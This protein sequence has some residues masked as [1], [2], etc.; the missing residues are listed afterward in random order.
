[1]CRSGAAGHA[2]AGAELALPARRP[3]YVGSIASVIGAG[4]PA[5][6]F[7]QPPKN[8]ASIYTRLSDKPD[9]T[10]TS[11]ESQEQE[12]RRLAADRG[13]TVIAVHKDPGYSGALR[14]RPGFT[15]WLDDAK[16]ARCDH[17]LAH[18]LDRVSR[19]SLAGLA[20]FMDVVEGLGP[21]GKPAHTPPRFLSV[22]DR[23]DSTSASW[24]ME[25][26]M[27]GVFA[28]EE[29]RRI[30]DRVKRAKRTIK[31]QGRFTGGV[32]PF[33]WDRCRI[34]MVRARSS[35]RSRRSRKPYAEPR[36][37]SSETA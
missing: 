32:A 11:L 19:G 26:G 13:L 1:M 24:D 17:L 28:K 6:R 27:R 33:G 8:T 7:P 16:K 18:H 29:R 35:L 36:K 23:L 34:R 4:M 9:E 14:D 20:A 21:D 15:A 3:Q 30:S 22:D 25:V 10:S 2:G 12:L 31:A 37:C 5:K